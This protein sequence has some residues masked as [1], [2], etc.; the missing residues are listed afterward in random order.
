MEQFILVLASVYN[1]SL[2]TQ[3]VTKQVLPKYQASQNSTY[4]IDSVKK[5]INKRIVSKADSL[6]DKILSCPRIKLWS[7]ETLV[8]DSVETGFFLSGF[9][10]QLRPINADAP[11]IYFTL[12]DAVGI[13]PTLILNQKA[14]TKER[15]R[16]VPF[17]IWT[18]EAAKAV[19]IPI[20]NLPLPRV[21]SRERR[22]LLDSKMK[23]GAWTWHTLIN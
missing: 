6:V 8:L 16:W 4:Q 19:H 3:S 13:S 17:K 21:D 14:K 11:D 7:S 2:I 9:A 1:K 20:Q 12:I 15:G 10:Q 18:S 5:E 22:H 23:F